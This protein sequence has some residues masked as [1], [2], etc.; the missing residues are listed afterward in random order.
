VCV[1]GE[2]GQCDNPNTI[3]IKARASDGH[4]DST[5]IAPLP[6]FEP[7]SL[8]GRTFLLPPQENGERHRAKILKQILPMGEDP[9]L[10]QVKFLISVPDAQAEEIVAYNEIVDYISD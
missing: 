1:G 2:G 5:R 10:D 8:I 9:K 4:D 3:F 7:D 6:G